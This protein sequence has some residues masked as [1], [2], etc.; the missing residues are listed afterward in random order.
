MTL[1]ETQVQP[2]DFAGSWRL[3]HGSNHPNK[4]HYSNA[5]YHPPS[6]TT[7]QEQPPCIMGCDKQHENITVTPSGGLSMARPCAKHCT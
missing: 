6:A 5:G 2:Q 7:F 1:D 3:R 4:A